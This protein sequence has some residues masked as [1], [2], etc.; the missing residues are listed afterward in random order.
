ME[1]PYK[2]FGK[3]KLVMIDKPY[4]LEK[5]PKEERSRRLEQEAERFRDIVEG[6]RDELKSRQKLR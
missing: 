3:R 1:R 5:A 4:T 2:I 6:M